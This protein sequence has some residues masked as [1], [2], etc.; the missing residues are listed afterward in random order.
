MALMRE[1]EQVRKLWIIRDKVVTLVAAVLLGP[2]QRLSTAVLCHAARG[3]GS[4]SLTRSP[5]SP[6]PTLVCSVCMSQARPLH[7]AARLVHSLPSVALT[8]WFSSSPKQSTGLDMGFVL[9][10]L[11]SP[12]PPLAPPISVSTDDTPAPL[13]ELLALN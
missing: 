8:M 1:L 12:K 10:L 3:P 2:A 13:G 6:L 5:H 7:M 9:N 11:F 4:R